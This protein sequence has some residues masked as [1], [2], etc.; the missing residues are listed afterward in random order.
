MNIANLII[1]GIRAFARRNEKL[2]Q[3]E[4][5]MIEGV[6]EELAPAPVPPH[7]PD[8]F[9]ISAIDLS[10]LQL[11]SRNATEDWVKPIRDACRL[12]EINT[13][14]RVA[15]FITTLAHEGNFKTGV[16]ENMNYSWKRLIQVWPSRFRAN[17]AKAK[18]LHRNPQAIANEVYANRMGNG[19]PSSGD[20]WRYR[21][22]G[23]IQLTGKDNHQRFADSVGKTVE[24]AAAWIEGSIEGSVAAA[25]WFWEE[26][27]INRLADTPDVEDET[28]RINGGHIGIA[29]RRTK[30]NKLVR[31][32]LRR[33]KL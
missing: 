3:H 2:T 13:I 10:L 23:A 21:G 6:E 4:V 9:P 29:D 7:V 8:H 17:P 26:N 32:L 28:K 11:V 18:R 12:M 1:D 31:E 16:R 27:G 33:E 19:P 14:R 20:G 22:N 15:A 24:Q 5:D 30:F 25:A